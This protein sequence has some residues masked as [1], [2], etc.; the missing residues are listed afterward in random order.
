VKTNSLP[1][2]CNPNSTAL[3]HLFL[4]AAAD[5][6]LSSK[7]IFDFRGADLFYRKRKPLGIVQDVQPKWFNF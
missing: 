2:K 6:A 1:Q 4:L 3:S 5:A 7:S